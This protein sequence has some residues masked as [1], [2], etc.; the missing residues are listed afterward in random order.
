MQK[1][2]E[3]LEGAYV[4]VGLVG[5]VALAVAFGAAALGAGESAMALVTFG[6]AVIGFAIGVSASL[7]AGGS[8]GK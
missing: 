8:R 1:R 2:I 6:C 5:V 4:P 7:S 3:Y